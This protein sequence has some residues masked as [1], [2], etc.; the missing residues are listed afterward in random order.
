MTYKS[1]SN[2]IALY[3]STQNYD[4]NT[5]KI[6]VEYGD[7]TYID[8]GMESSYKQIL[9]LTGDSILKV[10]VENLVEEDYNNEK[11]EEFSLIIYEIEDMEYH[12]NKIETNNLQKINY[13]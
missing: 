10:K 5:R 6:T 13:L 12:F 7:K 8:G 1:D 3:Y 4:N 2:F 9:N 11:N